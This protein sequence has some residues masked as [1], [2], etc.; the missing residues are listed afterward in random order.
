[1]QYL[2]ESIRV[3]AKSIDSFRPLLDI[4]AQP[5]VYP[6]Y[7]NGFKQPVT[8]LKLYLQPNIKTN[9]LLAAYQYYFSDFGVNPSADIIENFAEIICALQTVGGMPIFD[10]PRFKYLD[11]EIELWLPMLF[12]PPLMQV[13]YLAANF[14][15]YHLKQSNFIADEKWSQQIH[16]IIRYLK[17]H[18]PQGGNSIRFLKAAAELNIPWSHFALNCFRHGDGIHSKLLDSAF[19]D[20]TSHIGTALTN[21][22][23]VISTLLYRHGFPTPLQMVVKSESDA[24]QQAKQIGFPVVIKPIDGRHG[25]GVATEL[26]DDESIKAAFQQARKHTH[27]VLVEQ[28]IAGK[29]YRLV[30]FNGKLIW[31][32]ERIAASVIGNG[33]DSII[34]LITKYNEQHKNTFPLRHITITDEIQCHLAANNLTLQSIPA[35]DENITLT[36]ISNVSAG[37]MPIA[38]F[39]KVH[40]DNRRLVESAAKLLR[41]DLVGIDFICADISKSY[42]NTGGMII[43]INAQPQLGSITSAHIYKQILKELIKD[44]GRIPIIVIYGNDHMREDI[45][46]CFEGKGVAIANNF[47]DAKACLA[48]TVTEALIYCIHQKKD[49]EEF[50][51]PF[52]SYDYLILLNIESN[53]T[54]KQACQGEVIKHDGSLEKYKKLHWCGTIKQDAGNI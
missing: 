42:K 22:K 23:H 19:T 2:N 5:K 21:N 38:V 10:N 39:D 9:V 48:L 46:K 8:C 44:Q 29:D 51:L 12:F 47:A 35:L 54:L 43:E 24:I 37:G 7:I 33:I 52:D 26:S 30:V 14:F 41:L 3:N 25:I 17:S 18:A 20:N 28:H 49:I 32:V 36:K 53:D 34:N 45:I 27:T 13:V 31:A 6:G 11:D 4:V 50:G 1:M 15:N 40:P 16:E